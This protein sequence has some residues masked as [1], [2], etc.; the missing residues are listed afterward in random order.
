VYGSGALAH[1]AVCYSAVE[2]LLVAV[3]VV[4]LAAVVAV[5]LTFS[6][7][8]VRSSRFESVR[9]TYSRF[10]VLIFELIPTFVLFNCLH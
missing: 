6:V 3:L 7:H 4:V 10:A 2:L 5:K 1:W 8:E 9:R